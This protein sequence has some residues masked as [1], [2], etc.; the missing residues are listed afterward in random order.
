MAMVGRL[1]SDRWAAEK[2]GRVFCFNRSRLKK[3]FRALART[4]SAH[5]APVK[6]ATINSAPGV[7]GPLTNRLSTDMTAI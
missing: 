6:Y 4:F 7:N 5:R 3:K 1:V 2:V